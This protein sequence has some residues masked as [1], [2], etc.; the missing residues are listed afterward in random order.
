MKRH[1]A[2]FIDL[3]VAAM[4]VIIFAGYIRNTK[5]IFGSMTKGELNLVIVATL[6]IHMV[7]A[8]RLYFALYGSEITR[9]YHLKLYCK[10]T[11]ISILLPYKI[12]ELYRMYCYGLSIKN[13]VKGILIILLDRFFDTMAL[14]LIV[15][16]EYVIGEAAITSLVIVLIALTI[17]LIFAYFSFPSL[18][19]FWKKYLLSANA[20]KHKMLLIKFLSSL[21]N[22]Y[23]EIRNVIKG[24]GIILL[25]LSIVAW[26][27]EVSCL[28]LSKSSFQK[29]NIGEKINGYLLASIDGNYNLAL[30]QFRYVS[31][32]VLVVGFIIFSIMTKNN[33]D[34]V[35]E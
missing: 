16:V 10:V 12:G 14:L 1:L 25:G 18:S 23:Y 27:I 7:R 4:A 8:F 29:E 6:L 31:I 5:M 2:L 9:A 35:G 3:L 19:T 26:G 33:S 15:F 34:G 21:N 28:P 22:L 17:L 24:R 32:T 11:P 13:S 30:N 20:S